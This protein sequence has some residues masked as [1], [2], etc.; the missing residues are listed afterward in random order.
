MVFAIR[1]VNEGV[2]AIT[3]TS[4]VDDVFGDLFDAGNALLSSNTCV[5][6]ERAIAVGTS[7][8]C[9][10]EVTLSGIYGDPDHRNV[11][12]ATAVDDEGNTASDRDAAT[13]VFAPSGSTVTGHV[14]IDL[15]HNGVQDPGEG[16]LAGV[17]VEVTDRFGNAVTVTTDG[18]GDWSAA[19]LPGAVTAVVDSATTPADHVLTTANATQAIVAVSGQAVATE[20]VGYGPPLGSVAGSIFLDVLDDG[21]WDGNDPALHGVTVR[22]VD[23]QGDVTGESVTT[24]GGAYGF[25]GVPAGDYTVVIDP[26]S[27]M[28]GIEISI[29]PDDGIDAI[30]DVTVPAGADVTDLDFGYRGTGV[31]GDTVWQDDDG[32]GEMSDDEPRLANI[33]AQLTWA[34]L[35]SVL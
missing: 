9:S 26:D 3:V 11:V 22:L 23:G 1:V 31:I 33:S 32:D 7:L 6:A 19:A 24:T 27:V 34:G 16:D 35:D 30:T 25:D 10:F 20:P 28:D 15:D 14:F 18:S 12:A 13:V 21:A 29:D 8:E 17:D 2:E 4:L 5:T